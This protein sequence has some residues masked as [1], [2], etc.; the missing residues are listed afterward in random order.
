MQGA[1]GSAAAGGVQNEGL[2]GGVKSVAVCCHEE[3][4]AVHGATGA[5]Q[6]TAA[7]VLKGLAWLQQGLLADNAQT[8][9][10][11]DVPLFILNDPVTRNELRCH[12]AHVGDGDRVG[13]GKYVLKGV[14]LLGHV[15]GGDI[16]LNSVI[17]HSDMLTATI[18][19]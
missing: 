10:F 8:F 9:D 16:D 5:A 4:T 1:P 6:A 15:L 13:E 18:A 14:A 11:L 3:I 19:G 12:T 17:S 2:N 7:A